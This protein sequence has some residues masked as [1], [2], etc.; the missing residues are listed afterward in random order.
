[1][2]FLDQF[3]CTFGANA[4]NPGDIVRTVP[5]NGLDVDQLRRGYSIVLHN[6]C[7]VIESHLRL[8]HLRRRQP[9]GHLSVDELQAIAVPCRNHTGIPGLR[10]FCRQCSQDVVRLKSFALY[11]PVPQ[12]TQQFF[13]VGQLLRQFLRHSLALCLVAGIFFVPECR[14]AHIKGNR[15]GIR[16]GFIL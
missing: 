10:T 9:H 11:Q 13:Q 15:H 8:S 14:G 5:L 2:I 6:L 7:L 3:P 1:M 16:L 4:C 12:Q